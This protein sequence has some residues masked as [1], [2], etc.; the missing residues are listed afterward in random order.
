MLE[1][2]RTER[3][4]WV[5]I[6][7]KHRGVSVI[8]FDWLEEGA[9]IEAYPTCETYNPSDAWLYWHCECCGHGQAKLVVAD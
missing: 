5:E 8:D 2:Y 6:S 3:G 7:G 9:C 1:C 4:S